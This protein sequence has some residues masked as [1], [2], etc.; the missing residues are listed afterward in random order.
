MPRTSPAPASTVAEGALQRFVGAE[1]VG[2]HTAEYAGQ[3]GAELTTGD[4]VVN[5]TK[6]IRNE[7]QNVGTGVANNGGE[8]T[9]QEANRI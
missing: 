4:G 8:Q 6:I 7:F 1:S 9:K 2:I 3:T 5:N